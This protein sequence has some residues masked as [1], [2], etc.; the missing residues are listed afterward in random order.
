MSTPNKDTQTPNGSEQHVDYEKR[1]KDLQSVFTKT[2]QE[3]KVTKAKVEALAKLTQPKV[4]LD[5]ATAAELEELKFSDPEAWRAKVNSLEAEANKKHLESLSEVEK[6]AALQAE[7]ERRAQ[8]LEDFNQRHPELQINDDV[9][10]SDIPPRFTKKLES[11][12]ISFEDFL[13]EVAEYLKTPKVIGSK[14]KTLEQPNLGKIGGDN[15]PTKGAIERDL[16][17]DYKNNKVVF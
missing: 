7:L 4:E 8:V 16:I 14:D 11:G 6:Q 3:L 15:T 17:A 9:I 1:Y 12:A 2:T 5:E 10:N 13:N